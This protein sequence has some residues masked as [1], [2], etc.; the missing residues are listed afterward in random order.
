MKIALRIIVVLVLSFTI[1]GFYTNSVN[2][3]EGEK[4]IGIG[5]LIFAFVLMPLFIYHRY[6]GRD[7]SR[8][9][10]KNLFQSGGDKI[11]DVIERNKQKKR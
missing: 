7:L 3:G 4:F 5:V 6:N 11:E 8:Y 9:S 1:F 10:I 2:E